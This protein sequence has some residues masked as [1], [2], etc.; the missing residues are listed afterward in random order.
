M[1]RLKMNTSQIF[2]LYH[3]LRGA[4]LLDAWSQWTILKKLKWTKYFRVLCLIKKVCR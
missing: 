1:R 4:W 3:E 2:S